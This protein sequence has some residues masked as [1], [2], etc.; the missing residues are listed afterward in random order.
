MLTKHCIIQGLLNFC[1]PKKSYTTES[2]KELCKRKSIYSNKTN[3]NYET[4]DS[5]SY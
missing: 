5:M 4:I 3:I 2:G 1:Y